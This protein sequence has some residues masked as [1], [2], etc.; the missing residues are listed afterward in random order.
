MAFEEFSD[1]INDVLYIKTKK[2]SYCGYK[3]QYLA[4][5]LHEFREGFTVCKKCTGIMFLSMRGD[6]L[7]DV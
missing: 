5:N 7:F 3:M 6:N 2:I 1:N 4:Q